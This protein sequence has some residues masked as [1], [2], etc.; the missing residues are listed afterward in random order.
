[1]KARFGFRLILPVALLLLA[2][3]L[4]C[5]QADDATPTPEPASPLASSAQTAKPLTD[6]DREA[7]AAFVN[8]QQAVDEKR[9]S[10]YKEFDDWRSALTEC[11][12]SA[13]QEALQEF[14]ASFKSVTEQARNLPRKT[15][16]KELAD[17]LIPAVEAEETAF[18]ALRDRWQPGNVSLFEAVEQ[19]RAEAARA[20]K[21]AEDRSLE[22][23]EEFEKG[24][25]ADE[26]EQME[27]FSY[28]FEEIKD[29]WDD[30]HD[31]YDELVKKEAKLEIAE[32]ISEYDLLAELLGGII[33]SLSEL[34][35]TDDNEDFIETLQEAAEAELDA[36]HS[37]TGALTESATD[38]APEPGMEGEPE[39]MTE[40]PDDSGSMEDSAA[41]EAEETG[42]PA[43]SE[44]Q[45][46]S[47]PTLQA[48]FATVVEESK[49]ALGQVGQEI[50]EFIEDKSAEYLVD[51]QDFDAAYDKLI[52]VW[53]SFHGD[54]DDWRNTDGG[55]DRIE[56]LRE[57]D[58]FSR[59][60]A[61]VSDEVRA[62]PRSGFLLPAYSLLVDA[63]EQEA[64]AMRA[65]YNSWR[66]FATDAFAAVDQER[67]NADRLRQQANT[68]LQELRSRP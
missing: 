16:T 55:C 54:Y 45:G 58:R 47:L 56:T 27:E 12:P 38:A 4:A 3:L 46:K 29:A 57:L 7:V 35:A 60:T 44:P 39:D 48:E 50:E 15:S 40:S 52:G 23:Q 30:Y 22:L 37:L 9:A 66:P 17:L 13:A 43:E 14:A 20:Q 67:A 8:Q 59:Q 42:A 18:R 25:T 28:L 36:L 65:L 2:L 33:E 61:Q 11:H 1:M 5:Q 53:D 63:A 26:I 31:A 41:T 68:A 34:V 21:S 62:L 10:L 19:K 24:P 51:V 49:A 6:S 64:A 32:L